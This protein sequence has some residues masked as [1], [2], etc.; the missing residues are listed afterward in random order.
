MFRDQVTTPKTAYIAQ[1]SSPPP[2]LEVIGWIGNQAREG[3]FFVLLMSIAVF[4]LSRDYIK[5]AIDSYIA[6]NTEIIKS[7][8]ALHESTNTMSDYVDYARPRLEYLYEWAK[9]QE[10]PPGNLDKRNSED[11]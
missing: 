10:K 8:G 3:S 1:T 2:S 11:Q 7:L 4:W 5:K 9:R 6:V